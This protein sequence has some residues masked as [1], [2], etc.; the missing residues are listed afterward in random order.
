M[1]LSTST[2]IVFDRPDKSTAPMSYMMKLA[3]EAGFETLDISFYD[4]ALPPSPFLTEDWKSWVYDVAEEKERLGLTFG[5]SHAYTYSFLDSRMSE[6][7]RAYHEALLL[8]SVECCHILGSRLCVVHP[9]TDFTAAARTSVSREKNISYF[10]R[11]LEKTER[12]EMEFAIEN[13]CDMAVVPFRKYCADAEELAE[14]IDAV[15]DE[16]VGACWDFEHADIMK[17]DQRKSLLLLGKRL[18]ATHVSDT[19]SATDPDLMHVLPLM[20][21]V[22][23]KEAVLT[24][25][26]I[27][28]Q[29]Y[30][31]FEVNNYGRYF[32]DCLLP[33]ALRLMYHVGEYLLSF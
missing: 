15:K 25:R 16:R 7:E 9:D 5:Q 20:G 8:R 33:E 27:D 12:F 3:K 24:L 32:P 26:E 31:S 28:Y 14:L 1:K 22:D 6:E 4:W 23:W 29:G 13:M 11:L 10:K 21:T 30:F 17:Q 19:H 18:K 2:N